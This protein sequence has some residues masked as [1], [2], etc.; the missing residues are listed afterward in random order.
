MEPRTGFEPVAFAFLRSLPRQRFWLSL[1]STRLSH[2][3][4]F[5]VPT[6]ASELYEFLESSTFYPGFLF[7]PVIAAITENS[8]AGQGE[9]V[10]G[11]IPVVARLTVGSERL[12][13]YF[14]T[15]R[16]I[17]AHLGKRGVGSPAMG[18]FFGWI[19][20]A[21]EDVFRGGK[22]TVTK[23][24]LKLATPE[25]ILAANKDNFSI[26]Y[27]EVVS[28]DVN[29]GE[30]LPKF[31]ILTIDE[32]LV[33]TTRARRQVLVDLLRKVLDLKVTVT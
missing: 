19:S 4:I 9:Q 26:K 6:L 28:V 24:G 31:T 8:M 2:R 7:L 22:E 13:L 16:I 3:G 32:K 29:L 23:R 15:T 12:T 1:G 18:N 20:G 30:P 27:E 25:G 11:E 17:V 14:T 10:L 21:V 33:F 5:G